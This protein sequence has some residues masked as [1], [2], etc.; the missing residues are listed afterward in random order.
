MMVKR[1]V[2]FFIIIF[3]CDI[4]AQQSTPYIL[5]MFPK[6]VKASGDLDTIGWTGIA[7][8]SIPGQS[9]YVA[10]DSGVIY[11]DRSP[12]GSKIENYHYKIDKFYL[13]TLADS[14]KIYQNNIFIPG[15]IPQ[16]EIVFKASD[17][18]SMGYGLFY[19]VVALRATILGKD[20]ALVSN[21]MDMAVETP[22]PVKTI[23]PTDTISELTPTFQ[24]QTNPGV[25]Y[26]D[27]ILS[28]EALKID[29]TNGKVNLQGLSISWQAITPNTQIVYGTSDPS[30]MLT[31]TPPPLSPGKTYFWVVLNTYKNSPLYS[32]SKVGLPMSFTVKGKP[33]A[34]P[35]NIAPKNAVLTSDKDS[36]ITFKWTNLDPKA[37]TFKIYLYINSGIEQVNAQMAVWSN[38]MTAGTFT[39]SNGVIDTTDTGFVTI[40]AHSVLTK[41]HYTWKV[42]AI[43]S[44]GAST[45][46][47]TSGFDYTDPATGTM[48]FY[49][50]EKIITTT[51][52][53]AGIIKDTIESIVGAVEMQFE[54]LSGSLEAPLLFYTD[55]NGY[56]N[57]DRPKGSYRITAVK[58][59]YESLVK[60]MQLD[61]G[62]RITDTFYLKR[63]DATVFGKV[64]DNTNNGINLVNVYAVSDRNDTVL[65]QT[66]AL[67]SFILNCYEASWS[68]WAQKTG[69]VTVQPKPATLTYGQSFS[70]GNIT[71]AVNPFSV[72]GT[73]TNDKSEPILGVDV[74]ILNDGGQVVGELASTPQSGLFSFSLSPGTY[75]IEAA[76]VG[77][78]SYNK[79]IT[80]S[81]S[82]QLSIVMPSGAA[83]IMGNVVGA[84]WVSGSTVY[85]PI[86]KATIMFIDS[87]KTQPD[88]FSTTSDATYGDFG[89]SVPGARHFKSIGIAAGF[90]SK[91]ELLP[92]STKPGSTLTYNDTL[93]SLGMI[94]GTVQMSG[95]GAAISSATVTLLNPLT[96]QVVATATSQANGYFEVRNLSDGT[97]YI[98]AGAPGF[99]MDSVKVHDTLYISQGRTRADETHDAGSLTVYLSPGQKTILWVVNKGRDTTATIKIKSPLQKNLRAGQALT[100]AGG[101]DYIVSVSN[102]AADTNDSIVDLSYHIFTVKNSETLHVDSVDLPVINSTQR[103]VT[104]I[105]DSISVGLHSSAPDTL[106]SVA[107][108]FRDIDALGYA[109]FVNKSRSRAYSF[110][111]HPP[112]DGSILNYYFKAFRGRDIYGYASET[113]NTYVN[114]DTSRLSKLELIPSSSDTILLAAKS[115]LTITLQGYAG[116]TFFPK[117]IPDAA[118]Q[119][120]LINAP[121]GTRF[122]DSLGTEI[123]II[124]GNDSS[125]TPVQL[126]AVVDTVKQHVASRL[127]SAP[128]ASI[129]FNVSSKPLIGVT[130]RRID[131]GNPLPITTSALSQAE[132]IA[133]GVDV[134]KKLL[135]ISPQWTVSPQN[136]GT[137][138]PMG[139]FK[140]SSSFAGF[141]RI[142][143][144]ANGMT[145]EYNAVGSNDKAFGLEVD[146][147]IT[148]ASRPDTVSNLQGCTIIFP[149]SV[150]P[151]DK[152]GKLAIA[153]PLLKNQLELSSG[154]YTVVGSAYDIIEQNGV[155]F[156]I[157][158]GDSIQLVLD[159]AGSPAA[160]HKYCIGLWNPDSLQWKPL[161]NSAAGNNGGTVSAFVPHFSRYAVLA[162]SAD[163]T[164][165]LSILPNPFSPD[166]KASDFESLALRLGR[167]TPKG[168]C[169]SFTPDVGDQRLVKIRIRIYNI[170]GDL[171]SSV[172]MQNI[173]KMTEYRLWWD[174]RTTDRDFTW[175]E[176]TRTTDD[177][178]RVLNGNK[179]CRNGRYF[180]MLTIQDA[181]GKEKNYMKQ[182]VLIK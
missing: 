72:S 3:V 174:G 159:I 25:P 101:G 148:A 75:T 141:V 162:Q 17:Q 155:V 156:Q 89:I 144:Q 23:G 2:L 93:Q 97:V 20:T 4:W 140:P 109:S 14:S 106:D 16:R 81:N 126:E 125:A 100:N 94:T 39:G 87:G 45:S 146:N 48:T 79:Q 69:Y 131:A 175:D 38:E 180:V 76:K 116:S 134:N 115:Q 41:N 9:A 1:F 58:S 46:G 50:K 67:G 152:S 178:A 121:S 122:I 88:T 102:A 10:P 153:V 135:T 95:S 57:R 107:L 37:N 83:M 42:F 143:A 27:L 40:N 99:F 56:L 105:S 96:S 13:Q 173:P 66:D 119:W 91:S 103:T 63:P 171:V 22:T 36:V 130:V 147:I 12:G 149:D 169:I 129:F 150:V 139:V 59:G 78:T 136:A 51:L 138:S 35:R 29:T 110:K 77:F 53:P 15:S 165:T 124:T 52:I 44:K 170:V 181:K 74:K 31:A 168:T 137:L 177:N 179:M 145:G 28:D 30:G 54:V 7:R 132:F 33:L 151:A 84:T 92:D 82:M 86:T 111:F 172:V 43:D 160:G 8:P 176:L 61:S 154:Q 55:F 123:S 98:R 32:S 21:E 26:Y 104:I 47:D 71:L 19:Y 64:V 90:I 182:A 158:G 127:A 163:L 65:T 120:K 114:P 73:V 128:N 166:K 60:T 157:H 68:V 113:F 34:K 62:A 108:F 80:V 11:Y 85:A 167:D 70:F 49:T 161:S 142:Y 5:T 164:S 112:K 118:I 6:A 24:W 133:E 18:S 117:T